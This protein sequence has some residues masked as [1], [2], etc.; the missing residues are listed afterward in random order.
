MTTVVPK[1]NEAMS[2]GSSKGFYAL[3]IV[4]VAV[5]VAG[6]VAWAT[7]LQNGLIVTNMRDIISWG[8][9]I[10]LFAWFVGVSAG[11]LI[12]SASAA[13]FK[14]RQWQPISKLA[15]LVALVAIALAAF[16]ILPDLGRPDRVPNLFIYPQLGSPL[17][18]DVFIIF[19]Y[20]I[21]SLVE[22]GLL[23]SADNAKKKSDEAKYVSREGVARGLAFVALPVAVFTHSI[24]AWI[25][26]L[27]ISRPAWNTALLAPLFLASALVSGL[28]L[29]I[30]VSVLAN[31][32]GSV[33]VNKE[34]LSGLARLLAVMILV[35]LFLILSEYIT[36][37][38]PATPAEVSPLIT[39]F[40]GPYWWIAWAQWILALAAFAIVAAPRLR[41]SSVALTLASV[42][43]L[44]EIFIYRIELVIPAFVNPLVQYPPGTSVGTPAATYASTISGYSPGLSF[45]LV[46]SYFPSPIEWMVG[47][48]MVAGAALLIVLGTHFLPLGAV[49]EEPQPLSKSK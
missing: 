7:Q 32:F 24:T 21:I 37:I 39:E 15:N 16:S 5:I 13:V 47:V 12:V 49:E 4:L 18:W 45:Q 11:G 30:F 48:A 26:G 6:A 25:F 34:T 41:R 46:G 22:L 17:V 40:F 8:L 33:K 9:Y 14:I 38:W 3:V 35:D 31:R 2:R 20:L 19:T 1:A 27:Q 29:V 44:V 23:I 42:L 36:A 28:A 43:V 10:S